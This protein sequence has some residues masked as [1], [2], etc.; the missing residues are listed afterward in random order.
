MKKVIEEM[1]EEI[2]GLTDE[3]LIDGMQI[4]VDSLS[5]MMKSPK[6]QDI[7]EQLE[8]VFKSQG[9]AFKHGITMSIELLQKQI[10]EE[11]DKKK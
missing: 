6:F 5:G 2:G 7:A 1:I 9:E 8:G 4:C 11:R 10:D 3:A